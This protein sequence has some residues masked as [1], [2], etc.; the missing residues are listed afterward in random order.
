VDVRRCADGSWVC[1]HDRARGGRRI[2]EWPLTLLR[3]EGVPTLA[4]VVAALSPAKWLLVE[5]KPLGA[6]A[7][8]A[9]LSELRTLLAPRI[10][11]TMLISASL[12]V[13]AAGEAALPG[14][15]TSWVF[16][17]MPDWLPHDVQLSPR[18]TLVEEL[19][20]TGRPLHPWTVNNARRMRALATL[21]V[22]SLTTNHPDVA[23]EVLGG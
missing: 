20:S 21:G 6:D 15:A 17:R 2:G 14:L 18:H 5:V 13:L 4:E 7:F 1:Q 3:R 16:D 8:A 22:A 10:G 11:T 19:L 9:G 23:V 12:P